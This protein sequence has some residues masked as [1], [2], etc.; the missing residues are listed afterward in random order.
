VELIRGRASDGVL[1]DTGFHFGDWVALDAKEGSYFGATPNDFTATAFYAHSTLLLSKA[2][3]VLGKREEAAEYTA[4]RER[5]V[6]AFRSEFF[7]AT[8]R[9]AAR[10]QTA[11]VL[12][13][14][15][16][17]APPEHRGRVRDTLLALIREN[18]GHL[19]TGFLGTPYICRALAE[20]GAL[21][22]AYDLLLR[23]DYPSWLYQVKMGATTVWEHWDGIK[24]DG[25]MW[26]ADMNS[27][28]HYAYGS[29]GEWLYGSVAGLG[30]DERGPGFSRIVFRPQP[31]G[32]LTRAR[33]SLMTVYGLAS[34]EW[35]I[36]GG[37]LL[38][39]VVVPHNASACVILPGSEPAEVGSGRYAF[40]RPLAAAR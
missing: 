37:K 6:A 1:W 24:P 10:T 25:S 27:F 34:I 39:E 29:V 3:G 40:S 9:I 4:L 30:L 26:S 19:V 21:E 38:V 36:E 20:S 2:A 22:A 15:F 23:E 16:D 14:V 7:T 11:C 35:K 8:G 18:G 32:G 13:L 5:I 12:S 33:A 17:L 28:N 31:G